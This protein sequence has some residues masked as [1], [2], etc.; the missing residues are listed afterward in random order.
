MTEYG[1]QFELGISIE[2]EHKATYDAL[3]EYV[4]DYGEMPPPRDFF[5]M[6][7]NDHLEEDLQYYVKLQKLEAE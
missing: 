3:K 1:K 5:A 2:A 4:A 7:T 6:I